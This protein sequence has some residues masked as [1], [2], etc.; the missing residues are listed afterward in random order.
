[1]VKSLLRWLFN[2]KA[3][4]IHRSS[5]GMED[6]LRRNKVKMKGIQMYQGGDGVYNYC[7]ETKKAYAKFVVIF[8]II[9][10]CRNW[11]CLPE[12]FRMGSFPSLAISWPG[13]VQSK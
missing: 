4:Q 10:N 2:Q 9:A 1:M 3:V 7:R 6:P 13:L 5:I 11:L 8:A 12:L